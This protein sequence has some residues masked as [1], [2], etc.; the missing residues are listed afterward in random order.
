MIYVKRAYEQAEK[1]DGA[2]FL[3]DRLWAR[4]LKKTELKV[5]RWLKAVSAPLFCGTG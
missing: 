5:E 4:G 1:S 2:R 3:V